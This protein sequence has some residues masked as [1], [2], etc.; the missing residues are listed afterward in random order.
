MQKPQQDSETFRGRMPQ[1]LSR[2]YNWID[3]DAFTTLF[4]VLQPS[5]K[6]VLTFY[7]FGFP[8]IAEF[9]EML[10]L[11]K[12]FPSFFADALKGEVGS[13]LSSQARTINDGVLGHGFEQEGGT[14]RL[15]VQLSK[16]AVEAMADNEAASEWSRFV[17]N[18]A[19]QFFEKNLD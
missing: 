13:N 12:A 5:S 3:D 2:M 19:R 1:W 16:S 4:T 15:H 8:I 6:E 11:T 10:K 17:V 9:E 18:T 7:S 14:V